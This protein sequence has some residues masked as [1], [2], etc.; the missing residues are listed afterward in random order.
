[1]VSGMTPPEALARAIRITG[2]VAELARRIDGI[3][4]QAISQWTRVPA[5]RVLA[6]EAATENQ[7]TRYDLRPDLYPR[8]S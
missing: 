6:V 3:T 4:P 1:M 7:V 8:L 5:E 2:S